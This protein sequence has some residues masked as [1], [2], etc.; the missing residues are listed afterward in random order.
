MA[1]NADEGAKIGRHNLQEGV[2]AAKHGAGDQNGYSALKSVTEE[3]QQ[4][5]LFAVGA[6]DIGGAGVAAAVVA[7]VIVIK[8][9]RNHQRKVD[10]AEKI[11]NGNAQKQRNADPDSGDAVGRRQAVFIQDPT[12][13]TLVEQIINA[14][15]QKH[16]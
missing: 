6:R 15:D 9:F 10:A 1:Q 4:A 13:Q 16:V 7:D 5:G 8:E 14:P 12:K 11:R 2:G 3:G